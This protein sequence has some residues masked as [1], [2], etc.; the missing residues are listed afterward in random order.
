MAITI[1]L[2][3]ACSLFEKEIVSPVS[4]DG[5][6]NY[7][8]LGIGHELHYAYQGS[9]GTDSM[10]IKFVSSPATGTYKAEI[11]YKPEGSP[12]T[13]YYHANDKQLYTSLNGDYMQYEHWWFSQEAN[14]G[15][16]WSRNV[17]GFLYT[18]QLLEKNVTVH[19]P[20]LHRTFTHCYKMTGKKFSRE[21]IDTIYF[22]PDMGIVFF[23]G[24][25]GK[26]ELAYRNFSTPASFTNP[27]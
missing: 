12:S 21:G 27:E 11:S 1:L 9:T 20:V 25:E 13:T 22:K 15:D 3:T 5:S 7:P 10:I 14:I 4:T 23:D 17:P 16:F 2:T 8:F 26:Y 19:T 6:A 24:V 18:Y